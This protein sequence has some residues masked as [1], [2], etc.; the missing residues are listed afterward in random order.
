[1]SYKT[2][3]VAKILYHIFGL[4]GKIRGE[5]PSESLSAFTEVVNKTFKT[6]PEQEEEVLRLMLG[7][8]SDT[9]SN[10]DQISAQFNVPKKR[11]EDLFKNALE[12]LRSPAISELFA[13]FVMY[14]QCYC[15][16]KN[17]LNLTYETKQMMFFL[18]FVFMKYDKFAS[19]FIPERGEELAKTIDDL[20]DSIPEPE[21]EILRLY[22][23]FRNGFPNNSLISIGKL[24][25]LPYGTVCEM[26]RRGMCRFSQANYYKALAPFWEEESKVFTL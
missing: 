16:T 5:L 26:L 3:Q 21:D 11:I 7:L 6:L 17:G 10:F 15:F 14:K 19:A 22:H 23:G 4:I 25:N 2:K 1:M 24:L 9:H 20:L 18:C 8:K 13:P 12:K